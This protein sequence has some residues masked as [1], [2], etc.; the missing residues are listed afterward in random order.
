MNNINKKIIQKV[1]IVGALYALI[2]NKF[3][4]RVRHEKLGKG[5]KAAHISDL[6]KRKFGHDNSRLCSVI[7][8]ESP[9]IIL[10]TGDFVSRNTQSF[11]AAEKTLKQLCSIAPA[12]MILGNHEKSIHKKYVPEFVEAVKRS[13]AILL[14]NKCNTLE[15]N[16]KKIKLY[17]I[18]EKYSVYKKNNGYRDLDKITVADI[19]GYIGKCPKKEGKNEQ[20]WLM[21]HNPLFGREYA[22][23]GADYTFS[24]HVHGGAVRLFGKGILSPERKFFPEYSKGIYTIGKMKLLVSGGLGKM[25]LFNPP[26]IVVYE[27]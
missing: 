2:E 19:E 12:Y 10:I 8:R 14:K 3:I 15:I 7:K 18:S 5:V 4:L 1:L 17:G 24:G 22:R 23:W 25:R 20:I 16:G 6:H 13:G 27:L 26:E 9:D 11:Y 21:A